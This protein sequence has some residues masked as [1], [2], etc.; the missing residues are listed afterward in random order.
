M[1]ALFSPRSTTVLRLA[2]L[3]AGAT[4]AALVVGP[5]LYVRSGYFTGVGVGVEQPVEF[6]HRHHV[7]DAGIPCLYCHSGAETSS[8]AGVPATAVCMGCH[9][10][11]WTTSPLL[12][13]VRES[14][15]GDRPIRWNRVHR[16]PD[17]AFFH[18]G[19]HVQ[20]GVDC[21]ECH[22]RVGDMA[23][24]YRVAPLSMAW[25]LDCHRER[26]EQ[27]RSTPDARTGLR[28]QVFTASRVPAPIP[29]PVPR[30]LTCS[31][32]HR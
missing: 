13:P 28:G 20:S 8:S 24:V 2:L 14:F 22:G 32:C 30:Q 31:A 26:G 23:H 27:P 25:C 18:H 11:I 1:A 5:M 4:L 19:I 17:F 21:S 9:A 29:Q 6:D 3:A 10:Q 15:F 12:A 16:L 7:R